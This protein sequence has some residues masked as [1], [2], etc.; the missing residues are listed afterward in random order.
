VICNP[1]CDPAMHD[2]KAQNDARQHADSE[3]SQ[4]GAVGDTG[5]YPPAS[6]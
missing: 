1:I 3:P 5:Q 4:L 2:G 6:S